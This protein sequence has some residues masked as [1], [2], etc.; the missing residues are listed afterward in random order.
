[1]E[2][3]YSYKMS[4]SKK[5][6]NK[7]SKVLFSHQTHFLGFYLYQTVR[8]NRY[9][10]NIDTTGNKRMIHSNDIR[11]KHYTPHCKSPYHNK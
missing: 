8:G 2:L 11:P 4:N 10:Q 6:I 3:S 1:M 5:E 7:S 9:H